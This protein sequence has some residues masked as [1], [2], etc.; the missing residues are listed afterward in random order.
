MSRRASNPERAKTRAATISES[1]LAAAWEGFSLR[2][3]RFLFKFDTEGRVL[4]YKSLAVNLANGIPIEEAL[5]DIHRTT[6]NDGRRTGS[7]RALLLEELIRQARKGRP[8]WEVFQYW[9]TSQEISLIAAGEKVARPE[10]AFRRVIFALKKRKQL[11]TALREQLTSPVLLFLGATAA[12]GY[13]GFVIGPELLKLMPLEKWTGPTR[14]MLDAG[15]FVSNNIWILA[16]GIGGMLA[17]VSYSMPN[18]TGKWRDR[19]DRLPPWSIYRHFQGGVFNLNISVMLAQGIPTEEALI[20]MKKGSSRYMR[21]RLDDTLRGIKRGLN[22]GEA[23]HFTEHEFPDRE[24]V[25]FMRTLAK[26]A[27]FAEALEGTVEDHL[28]STITRVTAAATVVK[29]AGMVLAGNAILLII[30]GTMGIRQAAQAL[31]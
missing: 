10:A 25:G 5:I 27:K 23:L 8:L 19:L 21:E 2:L 11:M 20:T 15:L 12:Y 18:L 17:L 1:P 29:Y 28:D 4:L 24:T 26:R 30:N 9:A 16:L 14:R 7:A 31:H 22:L 13:L 6:T 3:K